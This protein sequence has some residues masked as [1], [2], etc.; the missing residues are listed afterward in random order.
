MLGELVVNLSKD[1]KGQ[2]DGIKAWVILNID[3]LSGFHVSFFWKQRQ[4]LALDWLASL[5]KDFVDRLHIPKPFL[6]HSH[7]F[8]SLF[9]A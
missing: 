1:I 8:M 7:A 9:F 2:V 6:A 3:Q 5:C 4:S